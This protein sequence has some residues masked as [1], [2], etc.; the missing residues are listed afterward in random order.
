MA[1]DKVVCDKVTVYKVVCDKVTAY[2]VACD[3]VVCDKVTGYKVACDKVVCDK[4]AC[5]TSTVFN[6]RSRMT[7]DT[8]N[9]NIY[10]DN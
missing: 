3:K 2:K 10:S 9:M 1:C 7:S 4:V 8:S 5:N 6:Y